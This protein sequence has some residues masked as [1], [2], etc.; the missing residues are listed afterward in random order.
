MELDVT[1][2]Q[3]MIGSV[4]FP[5]AMC[6]YMAVANNK[7]IKQLTNAVNNLTRAVDVLIN[8]TGQ[9]HAVHTDNLSYLKDDET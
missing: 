6:I 5:I 2:L 4:G 3:T 9:S 1:T 7:T 8:A